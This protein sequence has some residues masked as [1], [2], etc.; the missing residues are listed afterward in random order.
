LRGT[1]LTKNGKE[2]DDGIKGQEQ[3]AI[4]AIDGILAEAGIVGDLR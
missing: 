3:I 1:R 2:R 4:A